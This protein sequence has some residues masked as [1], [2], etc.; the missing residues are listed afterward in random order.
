MAR[1]EFDKST[2][3]LVQHHGKAVLYLGGLRDVRTCRAL[4]AEMVQPRQLPDGLLEATFH[5]RKGRIRSCWRWRPIPRSAWWN[6][7]STT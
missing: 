7:R 6:R 3:W 4:Q 2:K 5:G 1:G